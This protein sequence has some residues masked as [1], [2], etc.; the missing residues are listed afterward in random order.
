MHHNAIW[1]SPEAKMLD[2]W[3]RAGA[4]QLLYIAGLRLNCPPGVGHIL[5]RPQP[6]LAHAPGCG[7]ALKS[8]GSVSVEQRCVEMSG[9]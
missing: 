1:I 9:G 6:M 7:Q 8:G 2:R 5:A 4:N 3:T